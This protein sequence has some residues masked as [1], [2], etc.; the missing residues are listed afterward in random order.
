MLG[1][2]RFELVRDAEDRSLA[3]AGKDAMRAIGA[4]LGAAAAG[5]DR[6][7]AANGSHDESTRKSSG[8]FLTHEIPARE[9]KDIKIIQRWA[10]DSAGKYFTVEQSHR[11]DFRLADDQEIRV[12]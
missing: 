1:A 6:K 8:R 4:E 5:Q 10:R 3:M 12:G 2:Q 11:R 9:W 7:A